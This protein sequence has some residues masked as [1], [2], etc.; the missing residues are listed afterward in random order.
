MAT[1]YR[2][3]LNDNS[4]DDEIPMKEQKTLNG[5]NRKATDMIKKLIEKY[6][7]YV[8]VGEYLDREYGNHYRVKYIKKWHLRKRKDRKKGGAKC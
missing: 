5:A 4:K 7:D 2:A 8:I 6:F 3:N 1:N